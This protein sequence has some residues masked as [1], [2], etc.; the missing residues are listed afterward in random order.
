MTTLLL[1]Q[2]DVLKGLDDVTKNV[3]G[4]ME[5][6]KSEVLIENIK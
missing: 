1:E 5:K 6:Y 3:H 4:E 2:L